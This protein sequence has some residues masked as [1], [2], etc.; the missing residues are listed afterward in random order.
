MIGLYAYDETSKGV[1]RPRNGHGRINPPLVS[2]AGESLKRS[3]VG[4]RF[5]F[6]SATKIN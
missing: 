3:V 2:Q 1:H 5:L 4:V 6:V